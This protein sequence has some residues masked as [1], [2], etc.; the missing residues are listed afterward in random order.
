MNLQRPKF[1]WKRVTRKAVEEGGGARQKD[2]RRS[3]LSFCRGDDDFFAWE[4]VREPKE[5]VPMAM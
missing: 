2:R 3:L 1:T 4:A 5:H